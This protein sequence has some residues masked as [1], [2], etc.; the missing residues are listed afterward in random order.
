ME[1]KYPKN[2]ILIITD[3]AQETRYATEKVELSV[4]DLEK[5]QKSRHSCASRSPELFE[6]PGFPLS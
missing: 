2:F 5:S 4:D 6:L 3:P 1:N